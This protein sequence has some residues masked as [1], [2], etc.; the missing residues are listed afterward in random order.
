MSKRVFFAVCLMVIVMFESACNAYT[1]PNA[2]EIN[3]IINRGINFGN[4]L[5]A[6]K[7]GDWGVTIKVQYFNIAREAWFT[8]FRIPV[9]WSAH[10][11]TEKPYTI[12]PNFFTRMD[13]VIYQAMQREV[14]VIVTMHH[15]NELYKDPAGHR[16]RFLAIWKQIAEHYKDYPPVLVFEPLNEPHDNLAAGEWNKLL[17]EVLAVI[18]QSNPNRTIVFGPANYNDIKQLNTLELPKDDPNIIVTAHYYLPY[19]FTHQG[20]H[21]V[22]DSNAWLGTKWTGTDSEKQMITK[23]FDD[24]A[25]WAKKNNRPIFIGEFGANSKADMDSRVLWTKFVADTTIERG[26]SFAYWDFCGE[27]FGIC[28][29]N[30]FS[31]RKPLLEALIPPKKR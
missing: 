4:A 30:K 25:A 31:F 1:E 10:A 27:Y 3:K 22:A 24:A 29:P 11:L 26:F 19:E 12:D 6:P 18:R 13:W 17:K 2:F 8:S 14:I 23:D 15:Y 7:E 28:D 20:A 21:W 16:E 5:E 9:C